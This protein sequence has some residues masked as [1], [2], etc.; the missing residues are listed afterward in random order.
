KSLA[1]MDEARFRTSLAAKV[2]TSVRLA[3]VFANEPLDFVLFFSSVQSFSKAAGQ[4][5]YAAGCTFKDAFAQ[6][7]AR[8]WSCP[9]KI[10][11][12]GYWGSVGVVASESYR[13]KMAQLGIGS[14][15]PR[16]GMV[17]LEQL[18]SAPAEQIVFLNA[19]RL[20]ALPAISEIRERMAFLRRESSPTIELHTPDTTRI[21][22]LQLAGH[23]ANRQE[24]DR[25][26]QR[27][28]FS[29]LQ[30]LGLFVG[31]A[32]SMTAPMREGKISPKY[33]R[34]LAESVR[35][36]ASAG[37]LTVD[38]D[39]C[40]MS[41][42]MR[43]DNVALWAEWEELQRSSDEDPNLRAQL[44]L[45]GTTLRALP[46]ILTGQKRATDILFPNSSM[47]LVEGIYKNNPV[48]DYFN[49]VLAD[50]VAELIEARIKVNP[51]TRVRILEVGAGTGGTSEGVFRR[52]KTY[53]TAIAE[54]CYTDL[55]KAFLLHAQERYAAYPYV[56]TAIFNIEKPLQ[57]QG[58]AIG[59]FDVVIA[60]NVL[61]ATQNIRRTLR[62]VKAALQKDGCLLLNEVTDFS[63]FA[64]LTF[65]LTEGWWLYEDTALRIRG[66]PILSADTWQRVLE[67]EGFQSVSF[68]TRAAQNLGQQVIVAVSD[69]VVR[70]HCEINTSPFE[71]S[72]ALVDV[73]KEVTAGVV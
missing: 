9:V 7:L 70:Q 60:T 39:Q 57:P 11:N 5:N 49:D 8:I 12:W 52:L 41:D 24:V 29:Q 47:T 64:H 51:D 3:Q 32:S 18:L 35:I 37:Y 13:T 56:R 43:L 26:F 31:A 40:S 44:K 59:T 54:Y 34:W 20:E 1:Q 48:A 61:H 68:P 16:A 23:S 46:E 30:S 42:P 53:E 2:D 58:I 73:S 38:G 6:H 72:A 14:I 33:E 27:L 69:G 15:Q 17:A 4:S 55:S 63:L 65:G 28:L 50:K 36:L 19:T 10:M 66:T 22:K 45:A 67:N 21:T 71:A 25:L 62:N